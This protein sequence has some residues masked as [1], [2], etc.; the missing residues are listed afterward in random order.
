MART[1]KGEGEGGKTPAPKRR[2]R[3]RGEGPPSP[4]TIKQDWKVRPA[5]SPTETIY[6]VEAVLDEQGRSWAWLARATK[7]RPQRFSNLKKFDIPKSKG[8]SM[9]ECDLIAAALNVPISRLSAQG[10]SYAAPPLASEAAEVHRLVSRLAAAAGDLER[11][12]RELDAAA[13]KRRAAGPDSPDFILG[14]ETL[15]DYPDDAPAPKRRGGNA[16]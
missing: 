2:G 10:E 13:A 1:R 16:G 5:D 6:R 7:I 14:G 11:V 8:L 3:P 15:E 4:K 12:C 9:S